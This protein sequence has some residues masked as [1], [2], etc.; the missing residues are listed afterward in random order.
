MD[1]L[2][3]QFLHMDVDANCPL[4][5]YSMWLRMSEI[6]AQVTVQCPCCRAEIRLID[7][8]GNSATAG[9]RLEGRLRDALK[10]MVG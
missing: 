3:T 8:H 2:A 6:I 5:G 9:S 1:D 4:C 7:D 10:R